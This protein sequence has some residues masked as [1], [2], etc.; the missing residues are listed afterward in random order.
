MIKTAGRFTVNV[1]Q[2]GARYHSNVHG[3]TISYKDG[4]NDHV[5]VRSF[6]LSI[7]EM[8][9]LHYILGRAIAQADDARGRG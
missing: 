2:D 8:R 6:P 4:W 3:A 5:P 9:D 1:T 7:E